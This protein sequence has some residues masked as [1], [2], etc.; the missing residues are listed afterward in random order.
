MLVDRAELGAVAVGL[1]EVV[2]DDLLELDDAGGR[3]VLE[4]AREALVQLGAQRFWQPPVCRVVDERVLEA[5]A[6][7][8]GKHGAVGLHEQLARQRVEVPPG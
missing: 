4:P 2:A 5:K 3:A 1:L 8:A 6:L 7:P